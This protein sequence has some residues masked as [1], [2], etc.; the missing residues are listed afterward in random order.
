MYMASFPLINLSYLKNITKYIFFSIIFFSDLDELVL[1]Q[2]TIA[3]VVQRLED[4]LSSL[5]RLLFCVA[6]ESFC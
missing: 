6:L 2:V 1:D 3:V 4:L 5:H